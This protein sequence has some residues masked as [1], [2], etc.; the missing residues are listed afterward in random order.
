MRVRMH[1][2]RAHRRFNN[3]NTSCR[4][5]AKKF[6]S[7]PKLAVHIWRHRL[8]KNFQCGKCEWMSHTSESVRF[9]LE[10]CHDIHW[11]DANDFI[12]EHQ[13]SIYWN[14]NIVS[15]IYALLNEPVSMHVFRLI[16]WIMAEIRKLTVWIITNNLT[17]QNICKCILYFNYFFVTFYFV[18]FSWLFIEKIFA[19]TR[20]HFETLPFLH[21]CRGILR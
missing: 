5:C 18:I 6:F 13:R 11:T 4:I 2:Q 16:Q 3:R 8:G 20:R 14:S 1:I 21:A 9:H 15:S 7:A 12:V 19:A 10:N 17:H